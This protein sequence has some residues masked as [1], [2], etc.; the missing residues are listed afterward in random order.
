VKLYALASQALILMNT[1]GMD[2]DLTIALQA[3]ACDL[4]K[5][6]LYDSFYGVGT[7]ASTI[8]NLIGAMGGIDGEDFS[9]FKC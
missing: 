6:I 8:E 4:Y 9:F 1:T 2:E 7:A 5:E 3:L